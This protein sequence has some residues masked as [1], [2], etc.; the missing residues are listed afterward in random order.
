MCTT[1]VGNCFRGTKQTQALLTPLIL[2]GLR[3][4]QAALCQIKSISRVGLLALQQ[5]KQACAAC[6]RRL[7][8]TEGITTQ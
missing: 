8:S 2:S 6:L 1:H 7:Y 5:P 4:V 3:A